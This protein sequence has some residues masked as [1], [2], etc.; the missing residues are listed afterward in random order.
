[1]PGRRKRDITLSRREV[2][3]SVVGRLQPPALIVLGSPA[4]VVNVIAA[5]PG[6]NPSLVMLTWIFFAG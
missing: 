1:M 6:L 2:P 4:E 3:P 5:C